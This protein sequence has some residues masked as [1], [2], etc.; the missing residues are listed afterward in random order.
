MEKVKIG[1]IGC[2]FMGQL[3]HLQNYVVSDLC[4]VVA[5]CDTKEK[6]AKLVAERYGIPKVYADYHELLADP[7]V[8]AVVA[9]QSFSNHVNLVPD[10]LRAKKYLLTEKPLCIYPG[11]GEKLAALAAENDVFHMVAYHKRSDLATEYAISLIEKWKASGEMGKMKY[12]R[13]SM[14]PGD[15]IGG[16]EGAL[17]TDE[18]TENFTPEAAALGFDAATH[19]RMIVFVNYYIHQ[20]NYMRHMFGEDYK[21]TF[22]DKSEVMLAV[23]SASGVCGV[24]EMSAYET[25]DD[26]QEKILVTFEKGWIEI[27]L[28]APLASQ[29]A[30]KVT[31]YDN[32]KE[33]GVLISPRMPNVCAM[34]NQADRFAKAVRGVQ[35]APCLSDEAV[36]DLALS[37]DY[38]N[39]TGR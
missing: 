8:E 2:G 21:L 7:E 29:Q 35:P 9:S 16:A 1:F 32:S 39:Y 5:V 26:W 15:W 12:V 23:E 20:V 31:Y 18:V 30:G 27:A 11:N 13:I 37:I 38:I 10:I 33:M 4:E 17:F 3:A 24:I 22:V 25:T 36:K 6:Q 28:P 14:P 34:R 19:D